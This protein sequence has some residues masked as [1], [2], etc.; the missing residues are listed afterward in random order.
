MTDVLGDGADATL[1]TPNGRRVPDWVILSIACVA[2][3]MVVLD[4]S[5]VNVALPSIGRDLH[6]SPTGLQWVIN[7]Y[8]LTFAGFLLLGG[9][10]ADLFGRRRVYLFGLF[11]FTAASLVGGVAQNSA[12]LTTARAVQGIGGAFLSPATLTI[13][14]TTFSGARMAK[15]LGVWSAVAGAGGAAGSILGGVLTAE[16]SWRWVLFVNIPIGIAASVAALMFLIEAKRDAHD[17]NRPKLDVVGAITVTAGLGALIYAIVGTD[18]H[19]WGS[20]YTLSILG[21]AVVLLALFA[22]V[23]LKVASTPLVPFRLFRSRSVTGSN[24]VM[25]L[26]G[27]AFFSMWYF[28]SLYLQN[29]LGYG[30]L[31]AGLAFFPMAVAIIIGAQTSA[32][33]LPKLGVRPLLLVGTA[34]AAVGFLG[35][36]QIHVDSMYATHVLIPGCM[37]SLA[38][39]L[40]FTPLASA[41]TADVHFTEAGLASGVLNTARQMGGSVGLAALATIAIDHTHAIIGGAHGAVSTASALTSGYARAFLLA[42]FLGVAAFAASFIVP[43]LHPHRSAETKSEETAEALVDAEEGALPSLDPI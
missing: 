4:V 31:K 2:Q 25:F 39:G 19:A 41:A 28:L 36:A 8:V 5:I 43:S 17:V 6:Y 42:A 38:L 40:L 29:V 3:F 13:I 21:T 9:R 27:A 1:S 18:T 32:R 34:L 22:Y 15:A 35:L 24:I 16:I 30:A 26:V 10:A 20:T 37:I 14:V 12:W 23:Q 7:A 33:L 11:L